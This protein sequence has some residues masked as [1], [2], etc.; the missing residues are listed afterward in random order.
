MLTLLAIF[1]AYCL[2]L[3]GGHWLCRKAGWIE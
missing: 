1:S 2:F 3:A